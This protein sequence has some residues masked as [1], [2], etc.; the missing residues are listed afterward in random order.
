MGEVNKA[1]VERFRAQGIAI[2]FPQQEVRLL[3]TQDGGQ[4]ENPV[5]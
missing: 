1:I 2:P 4:G 5:S 3:G